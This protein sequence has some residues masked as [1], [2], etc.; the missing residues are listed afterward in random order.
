MDINQEL[1]LSNNLLN[2]IREA[3]L[4]ADIDTFKVST[5]QIQVE[6]INE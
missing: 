1:Q 5:I 4:F 2:I 6:D 3:L